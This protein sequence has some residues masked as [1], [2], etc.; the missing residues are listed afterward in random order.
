MKSSQDI[1]KEIDYVMN[2]AEQ[3]GVPD[4]VYFQF[5]AVADRHLRDGDYERAEQQVSQALLAAQSYGLKPEGTMRITE[6]KLRR[7]IQEAIQQRGVSEDGALFVGTGNFYVSL[8]V[9][10]GKIYIEHGDGHPDNTVFEFDI[11]NINELIE[12]LDA[13]KGEL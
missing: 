4:D 9:D 6:S 2:F 7:I 11:N 3:M 13:I 5:I 1:Q 8:H 12:G 10:E